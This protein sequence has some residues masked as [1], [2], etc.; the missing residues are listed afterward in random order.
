MSYGILVNKKVVQVKDILE[1][2]KFFEYKD[3]RRVATTNIGDVGVSTIFLGLDHSYG[4]GPGLWFETMIFGGPHDQ[5]QDRYTTW[6]EAMAGHKRVVD[7][8]IEG[9]EP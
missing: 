1:W 6:D 5:Y 3:S 4:S 9:K 2:A 8:L 7:A